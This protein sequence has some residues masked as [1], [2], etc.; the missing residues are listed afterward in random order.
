[1][2]KHDPIP[3]LG[4]L[5]NA[6]GP[7]LRQIR[8][9]DALCACLELLPPELEGLA[10]PLDIRLAPREGAPGRG[11]G[12]APDTAPAEEAQPLLSTMYIL[13]ASPTVSSIIGQRSAQLIEAINAQLAYP[14]IEALRC[15]QASA[16]KIERQMNILRLEP[17]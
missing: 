14:I 10:A 11:A 16:Q 2:T 4:P 6:A 8:K 13:C 7:L 15:E 1:M 3:V 17:D 9:Y 12:P 5:R